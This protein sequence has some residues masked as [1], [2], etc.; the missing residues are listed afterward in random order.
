MGGTAL[1]GP[2]SRNALPG[3]VMVP[4]IDVSEEAAPT[5]SGIS[6]MPT[7]IAPVV[8]LALGLELNYLRHNAWSRRECG[9]HLS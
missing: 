2:P 9:W 5:S 4:V 3:A 8:L 7:H 6:P 1:V